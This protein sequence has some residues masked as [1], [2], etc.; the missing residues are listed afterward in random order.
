MVIFS[1][2]KS[3]ILNRNLYG[4]ISD[5]VSK[6]R[7]AENFMIN[8]VL[9]EW[10][11]ISSLKPF[12]RMHAIEAIT[13]SAKTH[14][15]PKYDFDG[16]FSQFPSYFRRAV[17]NAAIGK[18][19]SYKSNLE[20]WKDGG[21]IGKEP[22]FPSAGY[23]FPVM[24]NNRCFKIINYATVKIKV[25]IRNTWDW[26]TVSLRKSDMDYIH[27]HCF[28]REKL[29]PTLVKNQ[30]SWYLA[31]PFE[32]NVTLNDTPLFAQKVM[33]VDLG[34]NSACVCSL[35]SADG[36]IH[37]RAFLS[38]D[39]EEDSLRNALNDIK[40][41]QRRGNRRMPSLWAR[42]NGV[43]RD[44]AVKTAVFII[45][46][47]ILWG[48]DVIVFEHLDIKKRARGKSKRQRLHLWKK[49]FV[50][51][52]VEHKAHRLCIRVRRICAWGTSKLAY[53]GSGEVERDDNNRA[54]CTFKTGK[55]YNCDLSAS[56]NIG[57]RYFIR[58]IWNGLAKSKQDKI[59][60]SVPEAGSAPKRTLSTL[61]KLFPV[62]GLA[63]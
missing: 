37:A 6:Y 29:V 27:R 8:V 51:K 1:T 47:A 26:I 13:H 41:K 38:L 45:E 10:D 52:V 31:F 34:I 18:V 59:I 3:K 7:D 25:Y 44:I 32:E 50:Q 28:Y 24:Y 19:S 58:E 23:D 12:L 20:N 53:D 4:I 17:I 16:Q 54:L 36:T 56:Y 2:Y 9:N 22:S 62:A 40:K 42:A 15:N 57:A 63:G 11:S 48:V 5:T 60:E 55:R 43:N 30:K 21:R 35:M 14:L 61:W 33:G 39:D 46:K 49:R